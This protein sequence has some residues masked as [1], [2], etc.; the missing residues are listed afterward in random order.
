MVALVFV[1]GMIYYTHALSNTSFMRK[2]RDGMAPE[3]RD[4]YEKI[5]TERRNL[6]YQGYA[7]GFVLSLLVLF[8]NKYYLGRRLGTLSL[9]CTILSVS[10]LTNYFYYMLSPKSDWMLNHIEDGGQAKAWLYVYRKHQVAYHGG[11]AL[12]LVAMGFFAFAFRCGV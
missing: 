10:F 4:R 3:L 6:F 11:L 7:L 1:V 5:V 8:L 2:Y 12:G 9:V